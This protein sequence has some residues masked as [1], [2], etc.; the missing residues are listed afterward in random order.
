MTTV[1]KWLG[2]VPTHCDI[3]CKQIDDVFIDGRT[4]YGPW[5]NMCCE[6]QSQIGVGLGTGKG[7]KYERD[8]ESWVKVA[9]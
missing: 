1:K 2:P 8:N 3:C 9:G 7:Q 4:V 5:A 6:C